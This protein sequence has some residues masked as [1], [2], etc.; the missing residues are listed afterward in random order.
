MGLFRTWCLIPAVLVG[1]PILPYLGI[2]IGTYVDGLGLIC[3]LVL[4]I[5]YLPVVMLVS[6][7]MP[8]FFDLGQFGAS[9][10]LLGHIATAALY[11]GAGLF[12]SWMN[13]LVAKF[14]KK[15]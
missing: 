2:W 8:L 7:W 10:T 1:F 5:Y 6:P 14:A 13:T 9:P 15:N 12:I 11:G 3:A 4:S